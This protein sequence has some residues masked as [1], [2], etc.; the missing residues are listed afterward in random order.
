MRPARQIIDK[1]GGAKA[2]ACLAGCSINYVYRWVTP[3]ESGGLG[4]RVP[5]RARRHLLA[6]ARCGKVP[7]CPSDFE[8]EWVS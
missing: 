7:L 1:C 4:G 3:V 5:E 2:T 6:A 8:P